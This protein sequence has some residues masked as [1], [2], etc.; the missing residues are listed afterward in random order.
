MQQSSVVATAIACATRKCSVASPKC[1]ETIYLGT[2]QGDK[3]KE[4]TQQLPSIWLQE[5]I[6]LSSCFSSYIQ[7]RLVH[8][9]LRVGDCC[10]AKIAIVVEKNI[11]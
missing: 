4:L 10:K 11:Y 9:I 8:V 6:I 7:K 1:F 2:D 3:R 5:K